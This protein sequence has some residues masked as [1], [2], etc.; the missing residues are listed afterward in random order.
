MIGGKKF[1]GLL[2][3]VGIMVFFGL[4]SIGCEKKSSQTGKT[5]G[6]TI[7]GTTFTSPEDAATKVFGNLSGGPAGMITGR[8]ITGRMSGMPGSAPRFSIGGAVDSILSLLLDIRSN[9]IFERQNE[10][11]DLSQAFLPS[12][13]DIREG[14]QCKGGGSSDVKCSVEGSTTKRLNFDIK[15]SDCKVYEG[16]VSTVSTGSIKGYMELA[17][18]IPSGISVRDTTGGLK[19]IYF[20]ESQ[21][22][23][24]SEIRG[25]REAWKLRTVAKNYMTEFSISGDTSGMMR[26]G[27]KLSGSYSNEDILNNRRDEYLFE[28]FGIEVTMS[29]SGFQ[30]LA[31]GRFQRLSSFPTS[32][33]R[34]EGKY[35]F[36]TSPKDECVKGEFVFKTIEAI[37]QEF[38]SGITE[39]FLCSK[40]GKFQVNNAIFEFS[41]G[42][43]KVTVGNQS[44]TYSCK[45]VGKLC[46][47]EPLPT[48][49]I[50]AGEIVGGGIGGGEEECPV[51]YKDADGDGYTDGTTQVFC[52]Q[53][54]GYV[55]QAPTGD[56]D[57]GDSSI[58]PGRAEICDG[59]DNNCNGQI[60]EGVLLVFYKDV[61]GDGYTDGTTEVFCN[62][63]TG[64]VSQAPTGD[65][66]DND[67]NMNPGK[68]E[69]CDRKDNNCNGQ[70]DEDDVCVFVSAKVAAGGAHTCAIKTNGSLWCW[71]NNFFGQLGDRTYTDRNTP[72]QIMPSGA[73]SVSLGGSHTC[74]VKT[75]GSLW[76][77][78]ANGDGELGDGTNTAKNTPVQIMSSGVSS[79][80]LGQD[81]TCVVKTNGSLWCWGYNGY[82]QLGDGTNTSRNTPVQVMSSGVVSVALGYDHTCVI[83]TNG[84]LWCWGNNTS[85]QLGDGTNIDK[86]APVQIMPS[87]VS[88]VSLGQYYTCAVKV[89]GSLWCWGYNGYGQLG[90]GNNTSENTPVQ[91]MA[92]GVSSV[93]L[94]GSHTCAIK[95]NGSLWC[96]GNNTSGQLGDGTNTNKNTPVQI[97]SSGVSSVSLGYNHTCAIKQDGSLWCWGDNYSSQLGDG[98]DTN[99][100]TPVYIMSLGS[101]GGGAPSIFFGDKSSFDNREEKQAN[102][103]Q[104]Q[105]IYGCS[106]VNVTFYII[107]LIFPAFILFVLRK[108]R[109]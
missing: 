101:G 103:G 87:G 7:G 40:R 91:I 17:G 60:D 82:G 53:P 9:R 105:T 10:D 81:Y 14:L 73:T 88:S 55:S 99:K 35:S 27:I 2:F 43:I 33:V 62:Q 6:E 16:G 52:K 36:N 47:Y 79:V 8:M 97:M 49:T 92:S 45:D 1:G 4:S 84:S 85:G 64:Y 75:N 50:T 44:F 20:I 65:C 83:K 71:G 25:G 13:D 51:W 18:N 26:L 66:N 3:L 69:I 68:I 93:S 95:T 29:F 78:G 19:I 48:V 24:V 61:D 12:C 80:E 46:E 104:K 107:Y 42:G 109:D 38:G 54:T 37:E 77:W 70:R 100:N 108:V 22:L 57:D 89:D 59:E 94:G 74:A 31:S 32:Y 23:M 21:D 86:N 98:T 63:P 5:G 106:S 39:D 72:I 56:C 67:P 30:N 15:L 76:C 28:S 34:I 96:W 11:I 90:D 102:M 41:S 58:N